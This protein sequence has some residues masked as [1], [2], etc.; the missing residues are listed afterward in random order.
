MELKI[1]KPPPIVISPRAPIRLSR[2]VASPVSAHE[3][4][5]ML[6]EIPITQPCF[7]ADSAFEN[8]VSIPV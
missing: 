6:P 7:S 8:E 1:K 3:S 4:A 5:I 2:F